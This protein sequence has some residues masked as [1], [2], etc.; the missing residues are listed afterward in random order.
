M[1][2]K[3]R[4]PLNTYVVGFFNPRD[5]DFNKRIQEFLSLA[6]E[7]HLKTIMQ[8]TGDEEFKPYLKLYVCIQGTRQITLNSFYSKIPYLKENAKIILDNDV[9]Y[10]KIWHLF[11]MYE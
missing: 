6:D 9:L 3:K 5:K 7:A 8:P 10:Q 1:G 4:D 2:E 11:N